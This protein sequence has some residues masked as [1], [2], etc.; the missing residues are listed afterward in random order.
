MYSL[1]Q[2]LIQCELIN[3]VQIRF[4]NKSLVGGMSMELFSY[5]V[6]A[7]IVLAILLVMRELVCW[8]WKINKQV[9]QNDEI[10]DLIKRICGETLNP[11]TPPNSH[12]P[13][14]SDD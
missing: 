8:Y 9:Q 5:I 6:I 7:L 4:Y 14:S 2:A 3:T 1:E 11:S 12:G 13:W 10:I